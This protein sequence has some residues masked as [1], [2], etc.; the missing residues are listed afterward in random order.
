ME[1]STEVDFIEVFVV[2]SRCTILQ[3]IIIAV[4]P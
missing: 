2:I 3:W 1:I 4:P